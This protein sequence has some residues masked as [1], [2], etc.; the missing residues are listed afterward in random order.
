MAIWHF[1]FSLLPKKGLLR[2]HTNIPLILD[3]YKENFVDPE[4]HV[5]DE[6]I[7]YWKDCNLKEIEIHIQKLLPL[8][9][10]WSSSMRLYGYDNGTNIEVW[11][12][13]I[14]LKIDTRKTDYTFLKEIVNLARDNNCLL[15]PQE[16]GELI[17]PNFEK[18]VEKYQSSRSYRFTLDSDQVLDE[19][20]ALNN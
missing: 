2:E 8:I 18:L 1:K 4:K 5:D 12:D 9:D 16:T 15:V 6:F 19:I 14:N 17:E 3:E 13:D 20:N 7:D 11:D 10:S